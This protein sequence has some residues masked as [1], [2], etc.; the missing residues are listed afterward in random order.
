MIIAFLTLE[1][2]N[3]NI[4][5]F[6]ANKIYKRFLEFIFNIFI[7]SDDEAIINYQKRLYYNN[8]V[9]INDIINDNNVNNKLIY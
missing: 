2:I 3:S 6:N 8:N 1:I 4:I 9:V 5:S 7:K